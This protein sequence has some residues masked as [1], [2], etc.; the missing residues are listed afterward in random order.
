MYGTT[1]FLI[2]GTLWRLIR[3]AMRFPVWG[4]EG[5]VMMNVMM[6]HSWHE[7]LLPLD[8]GQVA[9]IG[10]LSVQYFIT[11]HLGTSEFALRLYPL[12]TSLAAFYLFGWLAWICL[13]PLG[14]MFAIAVAGASLYL[15]RYSLDIKP[16]GTD[17]MLACLLFILAIKWMRSPLQWRWPI[18]L[19]GLL[20]FAL[21]FSFPSVFVCGA[22]TIAMATTLIRCKPRPIAWGVFA[23]W[24]IMLVIVFLLVFRINTAGQYQNAGMAILP[25]WERGMP[26]ANLL[27]FLLWV[28]DVHTAE[29]MAYPFG[30][31]NGASTLTFLFCVAGIVTLIREKQRPLLVLLGSAFALTFIASVL[32][33]Y[34]YGGSARVAQH[35][36]PAMV[37]PHIG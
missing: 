36:A 15:T 5:A 19:I 20:P 18:L 14:A 21:L 33:R 2:V 22:V 8:R 6:R 28:I 12:L 26:P 27:K 4:D 35:L 16:Y 3:Y 24:N 37:L 32:R 34:P 1:A 17:F 25:M 30:G 13:R 9:P 31:K 11:R 7:L 29:M 10:F 23:I